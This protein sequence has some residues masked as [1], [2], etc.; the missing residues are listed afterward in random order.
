MTLH[1]LNDSVLVLLL[2][3]SVSGV[4]GVGVFRRSRTF[5]G[6]DDKNRKLDSANR[7]GEHS[8]FRRSRTGRIS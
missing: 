2:L 8:E 3:R 4:T 1:T 7:C 5:R 6:M